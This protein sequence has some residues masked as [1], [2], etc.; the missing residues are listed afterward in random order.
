LVSIKL[1]QMRI[2]IVISVLFSFTFGYTQDSKK[3]LKYQSNYNYSEGYIVDNNGLKI[4]GLIKD[5]NEASQYIKVVFV[6]KDGQKKTLRPSDVSEYGFFR[7]KFVSDKKQFY[8]IV[9][10]GTRISSYKVLTYSFVPIA[11]QN[12]ISAGGSSNETKSYYLKKSNES[13][14]QLV[15]KKKFKED[16]TNY[17]SE[18]ELLKLKIQ[19]GELADKD[20]EK[21][22]YIYNWE[23]K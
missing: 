3:Y 9:N 16:L 12:G 13:K 19:N 5:N 8:E 18:C 4:N 14:F 10:E 6:R 2:S 11:G 15:S 17:F 21:I 1:Y 7:S 20:L 22:V 23:C